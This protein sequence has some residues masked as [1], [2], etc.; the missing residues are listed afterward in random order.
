LLQPIVVRPRGDRYELIAGERRV[1]AAKLAGYTAIAATVRELSDA[2]AAQACATE[3]L[4]REDLNAIEEAETLTVLLDVGGLTQSELGQRLGRSQPWIA[5][6]LRLLELPEDWQARI[7][8]QEIPPTHARELLAWRHRPIVLK[9]LA[10]WLMG[11]VAETLPSVDVFRNRLRQIACDCAKPLTGWQ[12]NFKPTKAQRLELDVESIDLPYGGKA[13]HAWNTKLWNDL[14]KQAK[15]KE[16]AA[17]KA[18]AAKPATS[19]KAKPAPPSDWS[20]R[21]GVTAW[22]AREVAARLK[23]TDRETTLRLLLML[24]TGT[25]ES[26]ITDVESPHPL[27]KRDWNEQGASGVRIW[28]SL[29]ETPPAQLATIA[30]ELV[31]VSLRGD[32][33]EGIEEANVET[34]VEILASLGGDP[35]AYPIGKEDLELYDVTLLRD[36]IAALGKSP[37]FEKA[38]KPECIEFLIPKNGPGWLPAEFADLLTPQAKGKAKTSKRKAKPR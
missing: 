3:N 4:E 27:F 7:I 18:E 5:N 31:V 8:S 13:E 11:D 26:P 37:G 33:G 14:N 17:A 29:V 35:L 24:A 20:I 6:R 1:R 32:D 21:N 30:H 38:S 19:G 28:R 12:C 36:M 10:T 34:L 23:K 9:K 25:I 22:L 16:Q 15:A 2:A